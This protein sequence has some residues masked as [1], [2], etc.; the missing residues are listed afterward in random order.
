MKIQYASDLHLEFRENTEYIAA[1]P[2]K[3]VGDI[4]VLAGDIILL[5]RNKWYNHPFFDW[6]AENYKQTFIVPGNHEYYDGFELEATQDDYELQL[7]ENVHFVNNTSRVIEDI[8]LF[9]S[10]LWSKVSP[11]EVPA[12]QMGMMD[13]RRIKYQGRLFNANDYDTLH[14]RAVA[15]LQEKLAASTAT[16]KVV[17]THHCPTLRFVD[18]RFVGSTINSA[19]CA[20]MDKFIEQFSIDYWIYGHTHYNGGD[21]Q[22][23]NGTKMLSNQLGYVRHGEAETFKSDAFFSL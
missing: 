21:G 3:V 10:T 9:F 12:I 6:C 16:H 17:V 1:N 15:A 13:C 8:E 7:R 18:P 20:D 23:I 19:F 2:L 22:F 11:L 4:L 14:K 5:G